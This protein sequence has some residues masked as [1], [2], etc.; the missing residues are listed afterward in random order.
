MIAPLI[1]PVVKAAL[2]VFVGLI[3]DKRKAAEAKQQITLTLTDALVNISAEQSRTNQIEAQHKSI[4]VAGWRPF[5]GWICGIGIGYHFILRPLLMWVLAVVAVLVGRDI[6]EVPALDVRELI[7]LVLAMLGLG[8]MRM[9][10]KRWG[11][12]REV[13]PRRSRPEKLDGKT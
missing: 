3:P 2:D 10:E 1:G 11:V 6:P 4:F 9:L 5:I 8:T 7:E 13:D 12:A